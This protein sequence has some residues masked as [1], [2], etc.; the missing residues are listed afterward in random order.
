M[1]NTIKREV[2]KKENNKTE[3]GLKFFAESI[4]T[5][6][7]TLLNTLSLIEG[8]N[9]CIHSRFIRPENLE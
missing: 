3:N 6:A 5:P 2:R 9:Y 4:E 7:G 8:K 1:L